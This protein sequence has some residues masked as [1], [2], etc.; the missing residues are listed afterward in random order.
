M[1][2]L[3]E[4]IN[5]RTL[6]NERL[7]ASLA[8]AFAALAVLLAVVGLYGLMSFLVSRRTREIG[9][10]L[11]LGAPRGAAV[12]LMLRDAGVMVLAGLAIGLPMV[13]V[14]GRLIENQLFGVR[15]MDAA[16]I[17]AASVLVAAVALGASA[18]P[19]RRATAVTPMEAL[20]YE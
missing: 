6:L 1:S 20:R 4:H 19:A 11:A 5:R 16:T 13:W 15:P 7:L 3:D 9:I 18:L 12:W 2:T 14:L 17:G 10:R 8:S